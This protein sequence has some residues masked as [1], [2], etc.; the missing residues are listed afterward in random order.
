M[1]IVWFDQDARDQNIGGKGSRLC[2]LV[3]AGFPV[4]PGFCVSI[5][6]MNGL[7][8]EDIATAI[9]RLDAKA[10][11][12]R[13]SAME[14]DGILSS[15]AG[16][17]L[18]RLNV[19]TAE[20]VKQALTDIRESA[21]A[22]AA[23][24]YRRKRGICSAPQMA[25]VV[26]EFVMPEASGVLF[27]RDPVDHSE[28]IVLEASWGLGEAVVAGVVTPDRWVLSREG[29][30]ISS[31]ISKKDTA[32]VAADTGTTVTEV[33]PRLRGIPC[34]DDACVRELVE[35]ARSCEKLFGRPQDIE[36]AIASDRIW[37]LQSR[38][39]TCRTNP[40]VSPRFF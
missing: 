7:N 9:E 11:A 17:Y 34:V 29:D 25:A 6:S 35:L 23:L 37:L 26:Q 5:E 13:S 12:V 33:D 4:P 40:P 30:V 14:E 19:K 22:P 36:W 39:I 1:S 27:L 24:A 3:Q 15:F 28:K 20:A 31:T 21:F 38:P 8:P 32:V 10:V 16:V 18:S 2:R